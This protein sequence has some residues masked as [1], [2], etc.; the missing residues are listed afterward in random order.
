VPKSGKAIRAGEAFVELF[1]DDKRVIAGLAGLKKRIQSFGVS[2]SRIGLGLTAFGITNIGAQL[3]AL[4]PAAARVE[5]SF[6]RLKLL[7]GES[8]AA[9]ESFV[10][11]VA[12]STNRTGLFVR[13]SLNSFQAFFK[14]L[15]FGEKQATELSQALVILQQDFAAAAGQTTGESLRR[16]IA[17]LAGSPEVLDQ[18]GIDLKEL[19]L[20]AVLAAHGIDGVRKATEKQKTLARL[21]LIFDR[22]GKQGAIDAASKA[23]TNF[24]TVLI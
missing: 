11:T 24:A 12:R 10:Q 15:Q 7:M 20:N 4:L 2:I 14:G 1:A 16:F 18:F 8:A 23:M 5:S 9:A 22:L 6:F 21:I 17:A 19:S 13:E 3:L